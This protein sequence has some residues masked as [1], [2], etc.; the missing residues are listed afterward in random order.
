MKSKVINGLMRFIFDMMG[1]IA[2]FFVAIGLMIAYAFYKGIA[3]WGV[4]IGSILLG[5]IIFWV[6]QKCSDK[7]TATKQK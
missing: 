1:A 2:S 3:A 5:W 4:A 6:L 7:L